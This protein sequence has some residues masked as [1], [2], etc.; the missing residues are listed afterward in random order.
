MATLHAAALLVDLRL[1]DVHS[2]K[3]KRH[4]MKRLSSSL[5]TTFPVGFAE[6]DHQD[7]WQRASIGVGIVSSQASQLELAVHNVRRFL[8]EFEGIEVLS[9][10]VSYVEDPDT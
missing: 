8:D 3:S 10:G 5:R 2:L 1:R 4:R 7:Q 6:V 9:V